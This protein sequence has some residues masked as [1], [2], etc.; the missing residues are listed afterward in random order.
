MPRYPQVR[1]D[2]DVVRTAPDEFVVRDPTNGDCFAI[3]FAER[4]LL[5]QLDGQHA[6]RA[7]CQQYSQ[8]FGA[9]LRPGDFD[10][11]VE[12]LRLRGLL[13]TGGR[14]AAVVTTKGAGPLEMGT[15]SVPRSPGS[16]AVAVAPAATA[17]NLLNLLFDLLAMCAGWLIHRIWIVPILVLAFV[18]AVE[19]FHEC[20]AITNQLQGLQQRWGVAGFLA[21]LLALVLVLISLPNA[22]LTGIACR[23]C[24]GRI[25]G[26]GL[27]LHERLLPYFACDIGDSIVWMNEPAQWTM[28]SLRVWSRTAMAALV[29][30]GWKLTSPDTL[31][32]DALAVL[33]VPSLVGLFLRLNIF[34]P[35]EGSLLVGYAFE[36]PDLY[37]RARDETRAWLTWSPAPEALSELERLWFRVY[38][39]ISY[40]CTALL[41]AVVIGGGGLLITS[42]YG[43]VGAAVGLVALAVWYLDSLEKIPMLDWFLR[44]LRGGGP[45]WIRW[46]IR[47]GL[48]AGIVA[49][50]F[51]PYPIEVGG[52]FR[53]VPKSE[54]G[55]RAPLAGE[56]AEIL[57]EDG[58][59]VAAGDTIA[60]L[61]G[62]Q[63][64]SNVAMTEAELDKARADLALLH[65]G[66]RPEPIEIAEHKVALAQS[67][68]DYYQSELDRLEKLSAQ[69]ITEQQRENTRYQHD[70]A[71][72]MLASAQAELNGLKV[73]PRQEEILAAE[74]QVKKLEALLAH[75]R[76]QLALT[77]II[78]PIAGHVVT[79]NVKERRGQHVEPG[80]LIALIQ[81]SSELR[82]EIACGEDAAPQVT[83]GMKARLHVTGLDGDE[84]L[85]TVERLGDRALDGAEVMQDR[86]RSDRENLAEATLHQEGVHYIRVYAVPDAN[87]PELKPDMTGYARITIQQD[88]RLWEA[89]WRH[90]RRF[91][92]VEAWSWLP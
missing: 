5:A 35:L 59:T 73:G 26:F 29:L 75:H 2:L 74:A 13:Q 51:I 14:P 10:D 32:N 80:D 19:F 82:V 68:V 76:E 62:R 56:I 58:Q 17:G 11:F 64:K 53:L 22:L 84:L 67:S 65:A 36:V 60:T 49:C 15:S 88:T 91:L 87:Q 61:M 6:P 54:C 41:M 66:T 3:R 47:L 16:T 37:R 31:L 77:K 46:P 20:G 24:G 25:R 69:T 71:I 83:P 89:L 23:V 27:H 40:A 21:V 39:V 33:I 38:G 8:Q 43:G 18:A 78:T 79:G 44:V 72:K 57:V 4:W 34:L 86:Y 42:T 48:L 90:L 7:I 30:L 63:E 85:A 81:D 1:T 92:M 52:E 45:W 50:G 28:L 55:I 9:R 12:Q 70:Q